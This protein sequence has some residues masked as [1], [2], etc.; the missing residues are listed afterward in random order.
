MEGVR[1]TIPRKGLAEGTSDVKVAAEGFTGTGCTL[2]T[3][4]FAR[5]LGSTTSE[6]HKPEYYETE[7]DD[8]TLV[9]E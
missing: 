4:I 8:Q 9:E 5:A 6:V 1:I 7:V 3:G 2:A